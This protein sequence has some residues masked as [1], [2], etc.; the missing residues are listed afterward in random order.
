MTGHPSSAR[1]RPNE[2]R[3]PG[4]APSPFF[5]RVIQKGTAMLCRL[6]VHPRIH[7]DPRIDQVA[8]PLIVLGNHPSF[9]DPPLM[10]MALV[11]RRINFLTTQVYFRKRLAG[12]ILNK[13]G[14]IPKV[15]FRSDSRAVKAMMRVLN[16]SGALGIFPEGQR[17]LDGT[18]T[19]FDDAI[20]KLVRKTKS[21]VSIVHIEGGYLTWPRWSTNRFRRGRIHVKSE[22]LLTGDEVATLSVDDIQ[23]RIVKALDYHEF[24]WQRQEKVRFR[25][26]KP[27]ESVHHILH[28]CPKC[29]AELAMRSRVNRLFCSNCGNTAVM[30]RY[31]F[32]HPASPEDRVFEDIR[33]WHVWQL[34]QQQK[35]VSVA[36]FRAAYAVRLETA[37]EENPYTPFGSGTLTLS[38]AGFD[39]EGV[40][41]D[42][43]VIRH[44]ALP[45][46]GGTNADF[47]SSIE[48]KDAD[49]SCRF[50]FEQGQQ[51][52]QVADRVAALLDKRTANP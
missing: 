14:A 18:P 46:R 20:A 32:F 34:T 17:S 12:W 48:L 30:D 19:P 2:N 37:D 33:T 24:D 3:L 44:F 40:H 29:L 28:Q 31:G 8:G 23:S 52:I 50:F 35:A 49:S 43:P 27:A 51:V 11:K 36:G 47:G 25:S 41:E 16:R 39:Y 38:E 4:N 26:A 7:R 10:A 5:Y 1:P 21:S 13:V 6:L 22:L 45:A 15:Q 42:Q 9:L